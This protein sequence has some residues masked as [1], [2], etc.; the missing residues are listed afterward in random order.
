[1]LENVIRINELRVEYLADYIISNTHPTEKIAILGLSFKPDS[2]DL[3]ESPALKMINILQKKG[4]VI[5]C[6]Y[7]PLVKSDNL[8]SFGISL[9]LTESA[10][11]AIANSDV[12]IIMTAWREF[13]SLDYTAVKLFD[14]RYMISGI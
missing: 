13:I 5:F 8:K 6:A 9:V 3:R 7:D 14:C 1:M 10:Q 12:V 2:D 11:E 4:R